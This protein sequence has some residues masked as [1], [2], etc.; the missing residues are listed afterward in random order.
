MAIA[1]LGTRR[2]DFLYPH[3]DE[4]I[5]EV[6]PRLSSTGEFE[7]VTVEVINYGYESEFELAPEQREKIG[8][9]DARQ[10]SRA[11]TEN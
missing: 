7:K 1:S 5:G 10:P 9:R 4:G 2:R 8:R 3:R 6:D 11:V